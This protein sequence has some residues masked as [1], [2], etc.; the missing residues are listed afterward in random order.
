VSSRVRL[1]G[2]TAAAVAVLFSAACGGGSTSQAGVKV[3]PSG[4]S[5]SRAALQACLQKNGVTLPGGGG[6]G[7]GGFQSMSP[8]QQKAFQACRSLAPGGGFGRGGG[9]DPTALQAF[10]TCMKNHNVV[11]P[12]GRPAGPPSPGAAA[13]SPGTRGQ[14][15]GYL[16]GLNTADPKVAAALTICRPLLPTRNA[17]PSPSA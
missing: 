14:G 1:L 15:G 5:G 3:S 8:E 17:S 6:G 7:G 13:P 11:V 9:F 4:G 10:R 12:T 16:R 2:G